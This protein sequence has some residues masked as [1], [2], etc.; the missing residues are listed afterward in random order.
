M[1][2][3]FRRKK[4]RL[5]IP[6]IYRSNHS[7]FVTVCVKGR[8]CCLSDIYKGRINPSP[9]GEIVEHSWISMVDLV[10]GISIEEFVIM[11]NHF[12]GIITFLHEPALRSNG[13]KINLSEIIRMFKARS[14][15]LNDKNLNSTP[16][17]QPNV[18]ERFIV[19][20]KQLYTP[21]QWQKSFYDHVIRNEQ[22]YARIQSYI[23]NNPVRWEMD[24]FHPKN[25]EKY[26]KWAIA[27]KS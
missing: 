12:H 26:Q 27:N 19:H 9:T 17:K 10:R 6:E 20:E 7:Y 2:V 5:P 13:K 16:K 4:N 21:F 8:A 22:D 25:E 15:R 11:P 18:E 23:I 24:M 3:K 1:P 14:K